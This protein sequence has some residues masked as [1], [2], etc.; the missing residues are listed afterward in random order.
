MQM[1]FHDQQKPLRTR[2]VYGSLWLPGSSTFLKI[3]VLSK[4]NV[5]VVN[6]SLFNRVVEQKVKVIFGLSLYMVGRSMI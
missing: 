5:T 4:N 2:M 3:E 6:L 1:S